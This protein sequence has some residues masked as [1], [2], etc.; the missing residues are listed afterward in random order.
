MS[1]LAELLSK[2]HQ[3]AIK[4][5]VAPNLR[6][7]VKAPSGISGHRKRIIV[8]SALLMVCILTGVIFLQ[9]LKSISD[10]T[11]VVIAASS[12]GGV[13]QVMQD[14][15]LPASE[16][17]IPAQDIGISASGN[18]EAAEMEAGSAMKE[19]AAE[20]VNAMDK[21]PVQAVAGKAERETETPLSMRDS[22]ADKAEK[23]EETMNTAVMDVWGDDSEAQA[24]EPET[25][26]RGVSAFN[27]ENKNAHGMDVYLYKAR[28]D[29][30][31]GDY[32]GAL[33]NY[34]K[35]LSMDNDNYAVMNNIAYIC[36][37]LNLTDESVRYARMAVEVNG[38]YSPALINLGIAYARSGDI[39]AARENLGS[40]LKL[41]PDN[42]DVLMNLAV[43]NERQGLL[44]E[45]A[46]HFSR[47]VKLGNLDG[48]M[49][50]ARIYEKQGSID[51]AVKLYRSV[52][53]NPSAGENIRTRARQRIMV[54][55]NYK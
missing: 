54:L 43:L 15:K 53:E 38:A 7:I 17:P 29:E 39:I 10:N 30:M 2:A 44:Q 14:G 48:A 23:S 35:A 55:N 20:G 9:Y 6:N 51:G 18:Q 33:T 12:P 5:A 8:V 46:E 13:S 45:A 25:A 37:R 1:M 22:M 32:S 34:K 27:A 24:D 31:K 42:Q 49:G 21:S 26:V 50:L 19:E 47:L 40:A 11:D 4:R 3:P 16:A 52:Y 41:E 28:E 36:L